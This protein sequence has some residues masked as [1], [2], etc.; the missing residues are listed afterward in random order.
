MEEIFRDEV[1]GA[2]GKDWLSR[3]VKAREGYL[4]VK[5]MSP[6]SSP[7]KRAGPSQQT[8]RPTYTPKAHIGLPPSPTLSTVSTTSSLTQSA[9]VSHNQHSVP[10]SSKAR[11]HHAPIPAHSKGPT[12]PSSL[13]DNTNPSASSTELST[14]QPGRSFRQQLPAL[15]TLSS[16]MTLSQT[17]TPGAISQVRGSLLPKEIED[18]MTDIGRDDSEAREVVRDIYLFTGRSLWEGSI[19]GRMGLSPGSAKAL[20]S[21]MS[22][23]S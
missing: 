14:I 5:V 1:A 18:F 4:S 23:I 8:S 9:I 10:P 15:L 12:A 19:T 7:A 20:V 16:T 22:T 13:V 17:M 2:Y 11:M 6:P 21:L 3:S